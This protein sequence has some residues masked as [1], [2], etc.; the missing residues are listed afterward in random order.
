MEE[1]YC[2][3]HPQLFSYLQQELLKILFQLEIAFNSNDFTVNSIIISITY[4]DF[5]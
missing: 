2:R 1:R 3:F 4:G 5:N